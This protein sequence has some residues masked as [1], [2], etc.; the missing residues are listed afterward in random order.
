MCI[1][2]VYHRW[3]S[4]GAILLVVATS[5]ATDPVALDEAISGKQLRALMERAESATGPERAGLLDELREM[6]R[7]HWQQSLETY[8]SK[9]VIPGSADPLI[10]EWTSRHGLGITILANGEFTIS[11]GHYTEGGSWRLLR[12]QGIL[13]LLMASG[14]YRSGFYPYRGGLWMDS[15]DG[16]VG[17]ESFVKVQEFPILNVGAKTYE[18]VKITRI[19]SISV[20]FTHK[21]GVGWARIEE[22]EPEVR[23][24]LNQV[25]EA[26]PP[27]RVVN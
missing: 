18:S 7:A 5:E 9:G 2:F 24:R 22:L 25:P 12:E 26:V 10:G 1:E 20:S 19:D 17:G 11:G 13:V 6:S 8:Y 15:N 16:C 27:L 23:A 21:T 4:I 14:Q 3:S